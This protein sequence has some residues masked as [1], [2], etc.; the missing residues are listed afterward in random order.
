M[1]YL[2]SYVTAPDY[3]ERRGTCRDEHLALAWQACDR[4]D[5]V[6]GGALT[7]PLDGALLL[8]QGSGPE[9][10]ERFAAADPYVK[11]G[12]VLSWSVRPWATVVGAAADKP[13]RPSQPQR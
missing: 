6:L 8:F 1:H 10:A 11:N 13:V 7:D 9:V 3:L 12:L 4:G 5:L 2:L